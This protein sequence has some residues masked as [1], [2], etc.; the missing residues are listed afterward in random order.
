MYLYEHGYP[1]K[2]RPTEGQDQGMNASTS[3]ICLNP[4]DHVVIARHYL[5]SS[6]APIPQAVQRSV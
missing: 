6:G 2:E 3:M 4:V 5:L 1:E